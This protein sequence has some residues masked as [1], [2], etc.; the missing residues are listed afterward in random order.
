MPKRQMSTTATSKGNGVVVVVVVT[1]DDDWQ[2][3]ENNSNIQSINFV[4]WQTNKKKK[5][6]KLKIITA[7]VAAS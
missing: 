6:Q 2:T 4:R 1:D 5:I 7:T 3:K